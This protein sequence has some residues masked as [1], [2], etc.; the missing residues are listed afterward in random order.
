M[1]YKQVVIIPGIMGSELQYN[2]YKIWPPNIAVWW[3]GLNVLAKK[4]EDT[5]SDEIESISLYKKYYGG[6]VDFAETI[7]DEVT[8]F[9]YDWRQ[10]NFK[11]IHR[12]KQLINKDADEVILIAHSMGGIIAKLFLNSEPNSEILKKVS[13][14]ITIGTPWK[15]AAEAY[16]CLQFGCGFEFI[17]GIFKS[18]IPCFESV[19]QLLP[20]KDYVE[21]NEVNFGYGYLNNKGWN[22]VCK[23]Y[24]IPLLKKHGLEYNDV[25]VKF[26]N[27]MSI[28]LP[29]W[30]RH[31]EIIGYNVTTLTS[32]NDDELK[33][34]G[35]Y[36]NG[37]GT[38]PLHSAVTDTN[39]KYFIKGKHSLLPNNKY[40]HKILK[41]IIVNNKSTEDIV[42]EHNLL[43]YSDV[44]KEKF[45]FKVVRVACPVNVSLLDDDGTILY[46]DM[47]EMK[48]DNLLDIFIKGEE[49][50]K[51]LDNDVYFILDKQNELNKLHVEAYDEGAVS[52]SI[53]EYENGVLEKIAKFKT[54]NMDNSKSADITINSSI[55]KCKVE[56]KAENN[57][58]IDRVIIENKSNEK[59]V[60]LPRTEYSFTGEN[61]KELEYGEYIA[62][63]D[64]Y[65]NILNI[66]CGTS[67]VIDTFYAV[68]ENS[69]MV[70]NEESR[71]LLNLKNGKNTI[72]VYSV[73]VFNNV[74][75][76]SEKN[77][78]YIDTLEDRVPKVKI[79]AT[80]DSYSLSFE[81]EEDKEFEKL[82]LPLPNVTSKF[83][84]YDGVISNF[85][86]VENRG[87][88][89]EISLEVIDVLGTITSK[90]IVIDEKLLNLIFESTATIK[91]YN[92]FLKKIGID[93]I[94][95]YKSSINGKVH[96]YRTLSNSKL[97][98]ADSL[99]FKNEK[100]EIIIDKMKEYEIMFN[101]LREYL[102]LSE[103][104]DYI[105]EFSV[106]PS[107]KKFPVTDI[108][109]KV[110]LAV[111]S[112]SNVSQYNEIQILSYKIVDD[113]YSFE[114]NTKD[115]NKWLLQ[116]EEIEDK[117][118]NIYIL[119]RLDDETDKILRAFELNLK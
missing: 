32:I 91:D 7:A 10:N 53:D 28:N 114:V 65:L 102:D 89:R 84:N 99:E 15:G 73:D 45:D 94:R 76:V 48:S 83:N 110:S 95:S 87:I 71:V 70:V 59:E 38:V 98:D 54:F 13:K 111:E 74:E 31:H 64:I 97:A 117:T 22:S 66:L 51:Y 69:S 61:I 39:H 44:L 47:S 86:I 1:S 113:R 33:V 16:I 14:L 67:D 37:D 46:G 4:L 42:R 57:K 43:T 58:E 29:E 107:N 30:V 62:T 19:Y 109:L 116:S 55:E 100:I 119:I 9:H 68:N 36:G 12:L 93:T 20:N 96:T 77:I 49:G 56:L 41:D 11:H 5:K 103:N 101:N 27:N 115:I 88:V 17:R 108:G 81:F 18:I 8:I 34:S 80:P 40:T 35:K 23:D 112:R 25:L 26:Y 105:F 50:V 63:G 78:Y 82:K 24:Y 79:K 118:D 85:N 72:K 2:E 52:I 104:K 21:E 90:P 6:L 75:N 106:F 3:K 92:A 60:E